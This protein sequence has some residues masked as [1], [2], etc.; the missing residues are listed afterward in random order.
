M[1]VVLNESLISIPHFFLVL[2]GVISAD[3]ILSPAYKACYEIDSHYQRDEVTDLFSYFAKS[4]KFQ[5]FFNLHTLYYAISMPK[6][7]SSCYPY[8]YEF[9]ANVISFV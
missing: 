3:M 2:L 4:S 1:S 8:S 7:L 6:L 9:S 5:S